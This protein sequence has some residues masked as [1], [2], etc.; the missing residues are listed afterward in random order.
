MVFPLA[1]RV[2]FVFFFGEVI[3][4]KKCQ[5]PRSVSYDPL[6]SFF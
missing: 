6:N 1:G 4:V 2:M 5:V 3:I